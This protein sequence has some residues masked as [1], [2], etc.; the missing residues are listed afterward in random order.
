MDE[1]GGVPDPKEGDGLQYAD[2]AGDGD[3]TVRGKGAYCLQSRWQCQGNQNNGCDG[4]RAAVFHKQVF[5]G[6]GWRL[7][8]S[9]L[10]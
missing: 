9:L 6:A 7:I 10:L 2:A 8:L 4:K 3:E 5:T 1:A